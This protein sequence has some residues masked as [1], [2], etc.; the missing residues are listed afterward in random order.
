MRRIIAFLFLASLQGCLSSHKADKQLFNINKKYPEK[1]AD[2]TRTNYPCFIT[3]IDTSF[4]D[5]TL[6]VYCDSIMVVTIDS[7][8]P[9]QLVHSK[10]LVYIKKV[11]VRLPSVTIYYEDSAKIKVCEST[12]KGLY[13]ELDKLNRYQNKLKYILYICWGLILFLLYLSL[14]KLK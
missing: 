1:V 3:K 14:R 5:T 4:I 11:P 2:F 9:T 6:I 13:N 10:P 8:K 7:T 12:T